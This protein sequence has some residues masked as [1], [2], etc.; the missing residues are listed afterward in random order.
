MQLRFKILHSANCEVFCSY[1]NSTNANILWRV[2]RAARDLAI[3]EKDVA[4][5]EKKRLIYE[6]FEFS[7]QALEKDE[8]NFAAHKWY[9]ITMGDVGDYEG[10]KVKISNAYVIRDHLEV[11]RC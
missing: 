11:S 9:A 5:D 6:A 1:S 8:T 10:V 2:A 7:K 4:A 3:K